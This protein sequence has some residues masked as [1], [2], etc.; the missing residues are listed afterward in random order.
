MNVQPLVSVIMPVYNGERYITEAIDSILDQSYQNFEFIIIDDGSTDGSAEVIRKY[1]DSRIRFSTQ[2]NAGLAETLNNCV[3]L[4][5]GDYLARQDCDDVSMKERLSK[6]V[7]F[8]EK[9]KE[10]S[11]VGTWAEITDDDGVTLG[12]FHKHP[13]GSC[14]LKFELLFNNPFVHS[15]MLIR[16]SHLDVVGLYSLDLSIF[17]DHNLWSRMAAKFMV[18]N[19]PELLVRYRQAPKSISRTITDYSYRVLNQSKINMD[20][21]ARADQKELLNV[22]LR[23]YHSSSNI[24][25]TRISLST[26]KDVLRSVR[27]QFVGQQNNCVADDINLDKHM[28]LLERNY[29]NLKISN[30]SSY[31]SKI[32]NKVKRRMF[33]SLNRQFAQL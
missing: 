7:D 22:M 19:L 6:Q 11:I 29:L 31:A 26:L 10:V 8:L 15:S 18:A 1:S 5:K 24:N 2:A 33:L 28:Y 13:V 25:L 16:R 4:A 27:S 12:K 30:S 23:V 14:Q 9:N 20:E 32:I 17:E 21:Y 3:K